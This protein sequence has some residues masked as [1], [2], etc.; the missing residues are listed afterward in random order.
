MSSRENDVL[1]QQMS[2]SSACLGVEA[3]PGAVS[4]ESS[5][6]AD[7]GD[8]LREAQQRGKRLALELAQEISRGEQV[9]CFVLP[10]LLCR[11]KC[12]VRS[13]SSPILQNVVAL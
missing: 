3:P 8:A 12:G 5:A 11:L 2:Q 7:G 4:H 10:R 9:L 13:T 6:S 1:R